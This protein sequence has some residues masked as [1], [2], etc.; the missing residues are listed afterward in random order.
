M[1]MC[2]FELRWEGSSV[3]IFWEEGRREEEH[4]EVRR[5]SSFYERKLK[6]FP[7]FLS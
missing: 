4:E 1:S 5:G 3:C 6:S 7:I 2:H